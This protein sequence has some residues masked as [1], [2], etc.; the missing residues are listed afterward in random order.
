M[1]YRVQGQVN[2]F[3]KRGDLERARDARYMVEQES[4]TARDG[5]HGSVS[6][7][8]TTARGL[9]SAS[10]STLAAAAQARGA[11]KVV[12][13]MD[14]DEGPLL[15]ESEVTRRLR[16][17]GEP[18]RLFGELLVDM[19]KRLQRLEIEAPEADRERQRNDFIDAME[20]VNEEDIKEVCGKILWTTTI[21]IVHNQRSSYTLVRGEEE[22]ERTECPC[23]ALVSHRPHACPLLYPSYW[24]KV[25]G[26]T[27]LMPPISSYRSTPG[28]SCKRWVPVPIK[29]TVSL[30]TSS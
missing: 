19:R 22:N 28:R 18:V 15:P 9:D 21:L 10:T 20:E 8:R 13:L 23:V 4:K 25:K 27:A 7:G 3:F 5:L 30:T 1:C 2:K 26:P 16:E 6:A 29:A 11:G 14:G 24:S 17:R 12:D